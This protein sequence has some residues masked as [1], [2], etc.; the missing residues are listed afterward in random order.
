MHASLIPP[1]R[2]I[3]E[4][5]QNIAPRTSLL[6]LVTGL[7]S[8]NYSEEKN[9]LPGNWIIFFSFKFLNPAIN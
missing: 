9:I 7:V 1:Y 6:L 8:R 4:G 5:E 3:G 2:W